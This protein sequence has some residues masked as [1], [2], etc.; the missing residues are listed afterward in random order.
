ME[1]E[2]GYDKQEQELIVY[3]NGD[4]IGRLRIRLDE[5]EMKIFQEEVKEGTYFIIYDDGKMIY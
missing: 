1:F 5:E 3:K 4:D 2:F